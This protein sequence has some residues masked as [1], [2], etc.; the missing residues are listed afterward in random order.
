[1]FPHSGKPQ[2]WKCIYIISG[3]DIW[4]FT[5]HKSESKPVVLF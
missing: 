2:I 1:M 3:V 5:H 4:A